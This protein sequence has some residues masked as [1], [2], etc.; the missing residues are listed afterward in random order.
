MS[1]MLYSGGYGAPARECRLIFQ[2]RGD[3]PSEPKTPPEDGDHTEEHVD[4]SSREYVQESEKRL[5]TAREKVKAMK[6]QRDM[7]LNQIDFID[8]IK[9]EINNDVHN[10]IAQAI[11]ELT[12]QNSGKWIRGH[13][14]AARIK[15]D[16]IPIM[17]P[18]EYRMIPNTGI[19]LCRP[20][21]YISL[22]YL[23][24]KQWEWKD[25]DE[26]PS[27]KMAIVDRP[28]AQVFDNLLKLLDANKGYSFRWTDGKDYI[29]RTNYDGVY[30][31]EGSDDQGSSSITFTDIKLLPEK[32]EE[33]KRRWS[34]GEHSIEEDVS[35]TK[36]HVTSEKDL[37]AADTESRISGRRVDGMN[38]EP[39]WRVT[40]MD[41]PDYL[42]YGSGTFTHDDPGDG[43]I[44]VG[45]PDDTTEESLRTTR[46]RV[47]GLID[48]SIKP[49]EDTP[50]E[51]KGETL[52]D[53]LL[54]FESPRKPAPARKPA[55][56]PMPYSAS[57]RKTPV[58]KEAPIEPWAERRLK[59]VH[60]IPADY[61][62]EWNAAG[63]GRRRD[64]TS[65]KDVVSIAKSYEGHLDYV[66]RQ[67]YNTTD[68]KKMT[69]EPCEKLRALYELALH[70]NAM[71]RRAGRGETLSIADREQMN[72]RLAELYRKGDGGEKDPKQ[73][74][75][76]YSAA[77]DLHGA[78]E[79]EVLQ[80]I[81]NLYNKPGEMIE[82]NQ[83][84]ATLRIREIQKRLDALS[85]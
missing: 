12:V 79:R 6:K 43:K 19:I 31:I 35:K 36:P 81:I 85:S 17:L 1:L 78:Q 72:M 51:K 49:G 27:E 9:E 76:F 52:K 39:V 68:S 18:Y 33:A 54:K 41:Y 67:G 20:G 70:R 4:E 25:K 8:S 71:D 46:R 84:I 57:L 66:A 45:G 30:R 26:K 64:L 73:A 83:I 11:Q 74:L 10:R 63:E 38:P 65:T 32:I 62:M 56:P 2:Y 23:K 42:E 28:T 53:S 59:I 47:L 5:D 55:I 24:W 15:N 22:G 14:I 60:S 75:A 44:T 34:T 61:L 21:N 48:G 13:E 80:Q 50:A 40:R 29:I 3:V 37:K 16:A 7:I 82:V 77:A 69:Q 58:H